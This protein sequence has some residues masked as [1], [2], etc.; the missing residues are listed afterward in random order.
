MTSPRI[1]SVGF[2]FFEVGNRNSTFSFAFGV[3][4]VESGISVSYR[5]KFAS[6]NEFVE[7]YP[8]SLCVVCNCV[9]GNKF[10]RKCDCPLATFAVDV[11]IGYFRSND[12]ETAS[13]QT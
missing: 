1:S 9:L 8:S 12:Y 13:S 11:D 6:K 7:A 3:L 5:W 10:I 2:G 4:E